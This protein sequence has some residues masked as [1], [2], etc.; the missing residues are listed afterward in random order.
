MKNNFQGFLLKILIYTTTLFVFYLLVK[1]KIP[2]KLYFENVT[3]L[4]IFFFLL[5]TIF[6]RGLLTNYEKGSRSFISYYMLSM[7]IKFFIY[8]GIIATYALLNRDKAVAFV[9]N[10]LA[11]Y[12]F[13]SVFEV[14]IVYRQFKSKPL[15]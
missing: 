2:Q 14:V 5:T 7:A 4:F 6:H 15:N 8:L 11:L 13:Y 1:N 10:F 12:L 3:Y 9:S